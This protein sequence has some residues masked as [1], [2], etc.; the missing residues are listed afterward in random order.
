LVY[1]DDGEA[2]IAVGIKFLHG[3]MIR[4]GTI[5]ANHLYVLGL[6]NDGYL[7]FNEKPPGQVIQEFF[8]DPNSDVATRW[9]SYAGSGERSIETGGLTGGRF[10]RIGNNSG[11]DTQ[12]MIHHQSIPYDESKL[13]RIRCRIRQTQG[14]GT[15][16]IG[17]QGRNGTDNAWVNVAGADA[18]TSG[19]WIA[20]NTVSPDVT[21]TVYTGY[22]KGRGSTGDSLAHTN[23]GDPGVLHDDV[24]YFRPAILVNYNGEAG[25]VEIDEYSID[26]IPE[27]ADSIAESAT[28][29]WAGETGA[30]VTGDHQAASIANQGALAVLNVVGGAQIDEL[31]VDTLHIAGNAVTLPIYSYTEAEYTL[32]A[33][34]SYETIQTGAIEIT[35]GIVKIDIGCLMQENGDDGVF[36][37]FRVLRDAVVIY[38]TQK[39]IQFQSASTARSFAA[40]LSDNPG[41]G[42]YDYYF[43]AKSNAITNKT[44]FTNRSLCLLELKK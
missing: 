14:S 36:C 18:Y 11:N 19:H 32:T 37:H 30:D 2:N 6:D 7:Q 16:H 10:H 29:K 33:G 42:S 4:A 38:E 20:G 24:R 43:Q 17:V 3:G 23:P 22:F 8:D 1:N 28:Q 13:Y 9:P 25:I 31:A 15:C 35:S 12:W 5:I 34:N 21:W 44:S 41:A 26:I 27:D 40:A 39:P